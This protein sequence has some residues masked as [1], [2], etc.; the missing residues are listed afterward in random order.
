[1]DI[2]AGDDAE[3]LMTY[4]GP[5]VAV[6]HPEAGDAAILEWWTLDGDTFGDTWFRSIEDARE[7]AIEWWGDDLGE[8]R[9]VPDSVADYWTYVLDAVRAAPES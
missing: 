6:L 4:E 9:P 2:R 8:W 3:K 1:M 7:S 5:G